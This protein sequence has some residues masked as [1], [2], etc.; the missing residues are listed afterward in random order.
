MSYK[1]KIAGK[2]GN[3]NHIKSYQLPTWSPVAILAITAVIYGRAALNELT[4]FDDDF[5]IL[6]NPFLR[7]WTWHGVK[8]IFT[9]FYTSNY[10]PLTTL[11]YFFEYHFAGVNPLPYHILNIVLHLICTWLVYRFTYR[12]SGSTITA[13]IVSLFFGIHP[14]HVESV[15]WISSRKDLLYTI[16][17]LLSSL[18]YLKYQ[19]AQSK[20]AHYI[21]CL[22]FFVAAILSKAAA[23]SL[24]LVFFAID[25]YQGRRLSKSSFLEKAPFLALSIV[26]GIINILAQKEGGSI[27]HIAAGFGIINR[28]FLFF[29]AISF[30]L[31]KLVAPI[32]LC[33]MHYFPKLGPDGKLPPLYYL[34][35][36]FISLLLWLITRHYK[37]RRD[38]L[39]GFA[40]FI[41]TISLMLQIVSV[42]SALT[43]ERYTYVAYIGLFY[44]IGQWISQVAI[45]KWRIPLTIIGIAFTLFCCLQTWNRISIW[46]NDDILFSD[47]IEKY[48]DVYH[49][50]WLRGNYRKRIGDLPGAIADYSSSL[51]RNARFEDAW[52][53][54]GLV[55]DM[56]GK[57]KAAIRDYTQAIKLSPGLAEAFNNRG[58]ALYQLGDTARAM[59][60]YNHALL[61]NPAY[62][63]AC[64]NRGWAYLQSGNTQNALIDFTKAIELLPGFAKPYYNRSYIRASMGDYK[65]AVEDLNILEKLDPQ[66]NSIYLDRGMAWLYLHDTTRACADWQ[67]AAKLGN[68]EAAELSGKYCR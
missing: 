45:Y 24:P 39:F 12:L 44:I 52:Y 8:A 58:W 50:Y 15:A 38:V 4:S 9:S 54:R 37:L 2:Q 17:F 29:S 16:F 22:I 65:G 19:Q 47:F 53:N 46:K 59:A 31:V 34:S 68:K 55:Y 33:A 27:N 64:N 51:E 56:V 30:Y 35:L 1:T 18:Q 49:G 48:P 21:A 42:G 57:P 23:V 63:Q 14:M 67:T 5:Y 60:D 3:S 66:D 13:A 6:N 40:F 25:W 28:I 62:P 41:F 26:F 36:P 11:S 7:D 61:L 20:T 10:H 32:G 43:A